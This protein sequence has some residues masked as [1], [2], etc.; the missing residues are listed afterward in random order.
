LFEDITAPTATI[1]APGQIDCTNPTS[2]LDGGASSAGVDFEWT[3]LTGTFASAPG[4]AS[5]ATVNGAGDFQLVVTNPTN[6]CTD[7]TLVTVTQDITAAV[8]V[9][10]APIDVTCND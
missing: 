2:I 4:N 1:A 7:T 3:E 8:A 10:A 6:G 5:T 9:I